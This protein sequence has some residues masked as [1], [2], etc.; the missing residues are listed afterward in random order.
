MKKTDYA[1]IIR[2]IVICI[3]LKIYAT[4]INILPLLD[5]TIWVIDDYIVIIIA[6]CDSRV[7]SNRME[8]NG[9]SIIIFVRWPPLFV[10]D[11]YTRKTF[12]NLIINNN[13]NIIMRTLGI[14]CEYF[15]FPPHS[16]RNARPIANS[17]VV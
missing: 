2:I 17:S 6:H 14:V 8:N 16:R 10:Y 4:L 5:T 9:H 13:I 7:K 1:N 12:I 15:A 11:I 3:L